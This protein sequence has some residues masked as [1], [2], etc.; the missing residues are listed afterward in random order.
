MLDNLVYFKWISGHRT[1][2]AAAIIAILTLLLNLGKIDTQAYTAIVGFL[3][4]IGLLTASVHLP[5]LADRDGDGVHDGA[6]ACPDTAAGAKVDEWG[7]A[8]D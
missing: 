1:Q 8:L 2:W 5:C 3:T 6:D 7:C 4:S